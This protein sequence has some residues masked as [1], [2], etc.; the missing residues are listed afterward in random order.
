M[1]TR[2]NFFKLI[3]ITAPAL[4]LP[5]QLEQKSVIE[6]EEVIE[7]EPVIIHAKNATI[8][9]GELTDISSASYCGPISA[10]NMSAS[11]SFTLQSP[12]TESHYKDRS[13]IS[14]WER[15]AKNKHEK[16]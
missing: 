10:Y 12:I 2:R 8:S 6:V 15:E 11:C 1:I 9:W 14:Y 7:K 16:S 3:G 5:T 4:V 13:I